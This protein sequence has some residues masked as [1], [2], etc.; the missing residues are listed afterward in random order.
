[1]TISEEFQKRQQ[2]K[3]DTWTL[4]WWRSE[5]QELLKAYRGLSH[6]LS[7]ALA[8]LKDVGELRDRIQTLESDREADRAKIGELQGTIQTLTVRV[9]KMAE[10]LTKLKQNAPR[11]DGKP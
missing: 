3:P 5:F 8:E 1:M 11:K 6:A 2:E 10:F 7:L 9:E 4:S